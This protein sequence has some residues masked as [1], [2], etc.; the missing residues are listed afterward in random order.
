SRRRNC[1]LILANDIVSRQ[2]VVAFVLGRSQK[3]RLHLFVK[4]SHAPPEQRFICPQTSQQFAGFAFPQR[5]LYQRS[6]QGRRGATRN[7]GSPFSMSPKLTFNVEVR[8]E[9]IVAREYFIRALTNLN[10]D[11]SG[12]AREL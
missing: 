5:L 8:P 7:Q 12:L 9:P 4:H 10:D 11:G 6:S 3:F 1:F 2:P